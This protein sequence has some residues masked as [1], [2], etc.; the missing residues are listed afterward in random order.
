MALILVYIKRAQT[1]KIHVYTIITVTQNNFMK[2]Y[3]LNTR[4]RRRKIMKKKP[5]HYELS[6]G[7]QV[8][9]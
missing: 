3:K 5:W 6:C 2:F 9:L 7:K 1:V 8:L 4:M